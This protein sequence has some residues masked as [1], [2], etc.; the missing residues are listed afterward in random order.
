MS[1]IKC[2]EFLSIL[3]D[4]FSKFKFNYQYI[5][6]IEIRE[7]SFKKDEQKWFI[8]GKYKEVV[9]RLMNRED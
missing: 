5:S 6:H 2:V 3:H 8:D 4:N 9:D 1:L 7:E